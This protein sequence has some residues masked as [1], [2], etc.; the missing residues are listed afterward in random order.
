M[1]FIGIYQLGV[2]NDPLDLFQVWSYATTEEF[3]SNGKLLRTRWIAQGVLHL[4]AWHAAK[5]PLYLYKGASQ[6][7]LVNYVLRFV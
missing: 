5:T 2:T 3:V 1:Q 7:I 4:L 6:L